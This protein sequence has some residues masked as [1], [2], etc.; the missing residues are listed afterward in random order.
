MKVSELIKQDFLNLYPTIF[1]NQ[2]RL[3]MLEELLEQDDFPEEVLIKS[4]NEDEG[5]NQRE[6]SDFESLYSLIDRIN[7]LDKSQNDSIEKELRNLIAANPGIK[8]FEYL[9]IHYL[10]DYYLQTEIF[11]SEL[12]EFYKSV[13][14]NY[15]EIVD[16]EDFIQGSFFLNPVLMLDYREELYIDVFHTAI[17]A[18]PH[19]AIFKY[20]LSMLYDRTREYTRAIKYNLMFLDQIEMFLTSESQEKVLSFQGDGMSEGD[21]LTSYL[22]LAETYFKNSEFEKSQE[23][24][25]KLLDHYDKNK[26]DDFILSSCFIEPMLVKLRVD[27]AHK[28]IDAFHKDYNLLQSKVEHDFFKDEYLKDILEFYKNLNINL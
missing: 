22:F 1:N 18:H 20:I 28:D 3:L 8:T 15:A 17:Q 10:V 23:Y 21:H 11:D 16:L 26:N 7:E 6:K 27:M 2:N 12:V 9:L 19:K 14:E 24:I 5:V 13:F 4:I 25:S